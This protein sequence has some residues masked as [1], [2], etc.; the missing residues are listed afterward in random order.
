MAVVFLGWHAGDVF[1]SQSVALPDG[2]SRALHVAAPIKPAAGMPP[3]PKNIIV[4][5]HDDEDSDEYNVIKESAEI[6][7][8]NQHV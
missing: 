1:G 8:R 3:S 7:N 5:M 4:W 2:G 6:F